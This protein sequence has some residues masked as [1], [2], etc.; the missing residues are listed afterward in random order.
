MINAAGIFI[1][2]KDG[3]L[4]V[5]HP[6]NHSP[7]VWSIP[8]GKVE[9][10]ETNIQA[11][12][13]ETYEE[14]NLY[15]SGTSEFDIYEL[16]GVKYTHGKKRLLPFLFLENDSSLIN[17]VELNKNIMCNSNV[18]EDRGGFLEM[19]GYKWVEI[20]EAKDMLH[21]TQVACLDKII[22]IINR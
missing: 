16:E 6:T 8:K 13:R 9:D 3:R 1:V 11:A 21:P 2:R 19:D 22:K 7:N 17:W 15:L 18:P 5:C 4:L 12:I 20:K 10:G 14:T